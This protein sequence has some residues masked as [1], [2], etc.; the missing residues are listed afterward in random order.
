MYER[1]FGLKKAPFK[2]SFDLELFFEYGDRNQVVDALVYSIQRG[3]PIV[4]VIGDVGCGKTTILR[5]VLKLISN[6]KFHIIHIYFP[7]LSTKD[8]LFLLC[9]ELNI[10]LNEHAEKYQVIDLIEQKL[11]QFNLEGHR[12][13]LM[14]D[15]AQV[16]PVD[17]LEELRMLSNL[18]TD[19]DK[20]LQIVLFGQPEFDKTLEIPQL[21]QFQSRISYEIYLKPLDCQ[22]VWHYL[23][24]RMQRAG[25]V[26]EPVFSKQIA[27]KIQK[28]TGG[29]PRQ[30]NLLADKLLMSAFNH[31][32]KVI[33]NKHLKEV[34]PSG[35]VHFKYLA[36]TVFLILVIG[37]TAYFSVD[38]FDLLAQE[39]QPQLKDVQEPNQLENS[40]K[41]ETNSVIEEK[42]NI[43]LKNTKFEIFAQALGVTIDQA[44]PIVKLL[45]QTDQK[46]KQMTKYQY[47]IQLMVGPIDAL[48]KAYQ[49]TQKLLP[50]QYKDLLIPLIDIE[51][52]RFILLLSYNDDISKLKN[53]INHLPRELI[54]SG[55]FV[56][57]ISK[58]QKIY[59]QSGQVLNKY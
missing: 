30:I 52:K 55:P 59:Q 21:R 16:M 29:L 25:Y 8:L 14:I 48:D 40:Q 32:D 2:L 23:N 22:E 35:K 36:V 45:Q 49:R 24:Y 41:D 1:F 53:I 19:T 43:E 7:S 6:S 18:E 34:L 38:K 37:S 10:S 4:K 31:H 3:D 15:E 20:L 54:K 44:K 57:P 42:K 50:K 56:M 26:G 9:K 13:L 11:L 46:I 27:C 51:K 47:T 33:K 12:V 39:P 17:T 5:K 58:Y 28:L